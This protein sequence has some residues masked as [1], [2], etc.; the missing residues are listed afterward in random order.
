MGQ[1]L[2]AVQWTFIDRVWNDLIHPPNEKNISGVRCPRSF[3]LLCAGTLKPT[4]TFLAAYWCAG[5]HP[6]CNVRCQ[7]R[8]L[9]SASVVDG[10]VFSFF[11]FSLPIFSTIIQNQNPHDQERP[12]LRNRTSFSYVCILFR[13]PSDLLKASNRRQCCSLP[14]APKNARR[15]GN[16]SLLL[17][18]NLG[19][20]RQLGDSGS[21]GEEWSLAVEVTH[22]IGIWK[23]QVYSGLAAM[24][25]WWLSLPSLKSMWCGM[26]IRLLGN[27]NVSRLRVLFSPEKSGNSN[28]SACEICEARHWCGKSSNKSCSTLW[29]DKTISQAKGLILGSFPVQAKA[30]LGFQLVSNLAKQ[31]V[32]CTAFSWTFQVRIIELRGLVWCLA[33]DKGAASFSSF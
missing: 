26:W 2:G 7:L 9:V 16:A 11:W 14:R 10:L 28:S 5:Q 21:G 22:P 13:H 33:G 29:H 8:T 18:L 30:A 32:T 4:D 3:P 17:P 31:D 1:N 15:S 6:L 23:L 20:R 25:C 12:K 19:L 27:G 24:L